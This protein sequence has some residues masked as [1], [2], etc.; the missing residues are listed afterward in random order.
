MRTEYTCISKILITRR[1]KIQFYVILFL[2][3]F[4]IFVK[5]GH[6]RRTNWVRIVISW[7]IGII[8]NYP[9]KQSSRTQSL[10]ILVRLLN[11]DASCIV[12]SFHFLYQWINS[13][14]FPI[15]SSMGI[16]IYRTNV[17][18]IDFMTVHV[19]PPDQS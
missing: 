15:F 6:T 7:L 4:T 13:Q 2:F 19:L 16:F 12:N 9:Q 18:D 3:N 10:T 17:N 14:K 11:L 8:I 5:D 1:K